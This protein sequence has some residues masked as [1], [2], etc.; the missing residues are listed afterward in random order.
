VIDPLKQKTS[1][2]LHFCKDWPR[3][4]VEGLR[5]ITVPKQ[6]VRQ[7]RMPTPHRSGPD[8]E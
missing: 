3:E 4:F 5:L 6:F 8:V 2:F 1:G 7:T